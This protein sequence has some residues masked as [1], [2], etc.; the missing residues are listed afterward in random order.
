VQGQ[1]ESDTTISAR[2]ITHDRTLFDH[3]ADRTTRL[4]SRGWFFA[5]CAIAI[6]SWTLIGISVRFSD[7]WN[8]AFQTVAAVVTLLLVALLQNESVRADRAIQ[9]KLN[10]LSAALAAHLEGDEAPRDELIAD[11]LAAVG[12]EQRESAV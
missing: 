1:N 10:T 5:G 2:R 12:L 8:N 3:V 7:G 11:L 4:L 6:A 9:R